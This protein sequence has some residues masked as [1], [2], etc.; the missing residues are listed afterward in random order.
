MND[1]ASRLVAFLRDTL[2]IE[3][4]ATDEDLLESGRLDS[5]GLVELL[6][7]LEQQFGV[8]VDVSAL[9]LENLRSVDAIRRLVEA[10]RR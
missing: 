1:L 7:F 9:E 4:A 5:L 10:S 3:V 8:V 6:F 2:K